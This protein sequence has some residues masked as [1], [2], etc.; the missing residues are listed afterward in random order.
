VAGAFFILL[1][2]LAARRSVKARYVFAHAVIACLV[3]LALEITLRMINFPSSA[4]VYEGE[5]HLLKQLK[6]L[7]ELRRHDP[8][9]MPSLSPR[10][11]IEWKNRYGIDLYFGNSIDSRVVGDEEDDGLIVFRTDENGFRNAKGVYSSVDSLDVFLTGDSF[12][13]GCWV[14]DGF[15][16]CDILRRDAGLAAYSGGYNGSG[17]IVQLAIFLEYGVQKKP[18]N[19]VLLFSEGAA[20]NRALAEIE[21]DTLRSYLEEGRAR[22]SV[23]RRIQEHGAQ[24]LQRRLLYRCA[25]LLPGS[26]DGVKQFQP[27]GS[28]VF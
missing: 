8:G 19:V 23:K 25:D 10:N 24:E 12:A 5:R 7:N 21:D 14:P 16:I 11:M 15:T 26:H 20:F 28:Q 13:Q 2:V 6:K 17:L 22:Y 3:L 1:S 9:A 4:N 27:G 18:K